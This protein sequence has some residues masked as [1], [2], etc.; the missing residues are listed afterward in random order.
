MPGWQSFLKESTQK[1]TESSLSNPSTFCMKH[2]LLICR[3]RI[4]P[5]TDGSLPSNSKIQPRVD[6]RIQKFHRQYL[7]YNFDFR[8]VCPP[9]LLQTVQLSDRGYAPLHVKS[10]SW[11][12]RWGSRKAIVGIQPLPLPQSDG[13]LGSNS[14]FAPAYQSK[15]RWRPRQLR[16]KFNWGSSGH[17]AGVVPK[18]MKVLWLIIFHRKMRLCKCRS[19][20]STWSRRRGTG[21]WFLVLCF[22][23]A[24]LIAHS[25]DHDHNRCLSQDY[26]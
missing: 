14:L 7:V 1:R 10:H 16:C 6:S 26:I 9:L 12:C 24:Q 15:S 8:K 5:Q 17:D 19:N 25:E 23:I 3:S 11:S 2:S 18:D 22:P 20:S 4:R 21:R 13:D